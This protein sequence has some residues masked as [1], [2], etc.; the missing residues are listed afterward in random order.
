MTARPVTV[1][2]DDVRTLA[3]LAGLDLAAEA[4]PPLAERL[5][6]VRGQLA[7]IPDDALAGIEPAFVLP[8]ART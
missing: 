1:T 8:L 6:A 4:L 2:V 3:K 5:A 7:A